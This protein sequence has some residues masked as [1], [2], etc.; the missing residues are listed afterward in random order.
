LLIGF[1][2]ST[3]IIANH[4]L[5]YK[6]NGPEYNKEEARR[7]IR[8]DIMRV[9]LAN[10]LNVL[11]VIVATI[12]FIIPG[13]YLIVANS[14]ITTII[15][16]DK[17][18][19]TMDA[20]GESRR[21]IR[22]NW[23]AAL[24]LGLIVGIITLC[25]QLIFKIPSSI[26]TTVITFNTLRNGEDIGSYKTLFIVFNAI[27]Y[28]GTALVSPISVVA[29]SIFYY[30]LK[31]KKDHTSLMQNIESIGVQPARTETDIQKDEGDF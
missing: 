19:G 31:E 27:A 17:Q 14:L 10:F 5:M 26:L 15:V 6:T 9:T 3:C 18:T 22:D 8:G 7:Y 13:I 2:L 1:S 29:S 16:L 24:G 12:F 4:V 28:L 30:S 25:V 21:L 23:W 11:V 20:F